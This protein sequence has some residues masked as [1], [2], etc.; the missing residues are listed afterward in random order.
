M[1]IQ[2]GAARLQLDSDPDRARAPL[3][4]VEET[5]RQALADLRR[6][7]GIVELG[8][9]REPV[10]APQPG[11]ADLPALVAQL[12]RAGLPTDLVV[13]GEPEPL[14]PGVELAAY[15]IA[16]EALTNTLKHAGPARARVTVRYDPEWLRLEITDDGRGAATGGRDG[17][18]LV[19]MRERVALYGGTLEVGARPAGG[20]GVSARL[21]LARLAAAEHRSA[22]GCTPDPP[23]T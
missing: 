5:G 18:G 3:L 9:N 10:L 1:T 8:Q 22:G 12:R 13:E 7:V 23:A 19:G 11:L 15:R 6:L 4:I 21:P 17:H 20:F 2:G 14:T 16:Q